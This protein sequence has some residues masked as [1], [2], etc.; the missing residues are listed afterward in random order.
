MIYDLIQKYTPCTYT[1][2]DMSG[3][4]MDQK[5]WSHILF[6]LGGNKRGAYDTRKFQPESIPEIIATRYVIRFKG[7]FPTRVLSR[8]P[9][10][11]DN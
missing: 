6:K 1:E 4:V 3:Y 5:N 2:M 11:V 10:R 8:E 7:R 9:P